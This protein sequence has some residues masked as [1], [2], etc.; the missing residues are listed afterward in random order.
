MPKEEPEFELNRLRTELDKAL[1]DEIFGG[2]SPEELSEYNRKA[3]RIHE[4][5]EIH[6]SAI[7]ERSSEVAKAEQKRHWSKD[8]ETD[9]PQVEAHQPYR[10]REKDLRFYRLE[11]GE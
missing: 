6:M 7:V 4:L 10:S 11:N 1:Q 9:T 3:E 2:L 8:P 5:L